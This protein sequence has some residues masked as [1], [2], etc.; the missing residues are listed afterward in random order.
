MRRVGKEFMDTAAA[1]GSKSGA[2]ESGME[3]GSAE[4]IGGAFSE[5]RPA[6]VRNITT[7]GTAHDN[8]YACPQHED[9]NS[10]ARDDAI[11]HLLRTMAVAPNGRQDIAL[12]TKQQQN[13]AP[14]WTHDDGPSRERRLLEQGREKQAREDA[15]H[16][17][18]HAASAV[19]V[20]AQRLGWGRRRRR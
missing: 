13:A 4:E 2:T 8:N 20:A 17:Q 9:R 1:A 19:A 16:E 18:R 14:R 3:C 12:A 6:A 5:A 11:N 7:T 10:A 15:L